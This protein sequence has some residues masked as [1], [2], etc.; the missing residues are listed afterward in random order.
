VAAGL[1]SQKDLDACL[2]LQQQTSDGTPIGQMLVLQGYLSA[3]DLAR[4][5]AQ[6][7]HIHRTFAI[8][9]GAP[10]PAPAPEDALTDIPLYGVMR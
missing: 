3:H 7:Q 5:V 4:I 9:R 1:V 2:V 8:T 6:Q 10:A